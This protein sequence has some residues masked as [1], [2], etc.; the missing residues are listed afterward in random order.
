MLGIAPKGLKKNQCVTV[1]ELC[2]CTMI[3]TV[4]E[5]TQSFKCLND[6]YASIDLSIPETFIVRTT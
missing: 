5:T 4:R 3:A 6:W 2:R 1:D